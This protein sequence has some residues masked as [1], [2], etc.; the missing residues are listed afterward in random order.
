VTT[1]CAIRLRWSL[2]GIPRGRL[3]GASSLCG[4]ITEIV[5]GYI[6]ATMIY[7]FMS[8]PMTPSD[9]PKHQYAG[10]QTVTSQ[11]IRTEIDKLVD[12]ACKRDFLPSTWR[13]LWE[14]AYQL[15]VLNERSAANDAKID[16]VFQ[17]SSGTAKVEPPA[18]A[19][20]IDGMNNSQLRN[21]IETQRV[22]IERLRKLSGE[23]PRGT[24]G[25]GSTESR[26]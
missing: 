23:Q 20:M 14:I 26:T 22:E 8:K 25:F 13:P 10:N 18:Q 16:A 15:A 3:S 9:F 11:E 5:R 24:A 4:Q 7:S 21:F 2:I 17:R 12:A 1:A 19:D 6:N